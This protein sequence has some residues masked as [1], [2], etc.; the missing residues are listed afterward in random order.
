MAL[1]QSCMPE[2]KLTSPK[3]V[4]A[5]LFHFLCKLNARKRETVPIQSAFNFYHSVAASWLDWIS[6]SVCATHCPPGK[7]FVHR[8]ACSVVRSLDPYVVFMP[9][10]HLK[11]ALVAG[12][13]GVHCRLWDTLRGCAVVT[14]QDVTS[15]GYASDCCIT[16]ENMWG[17]SPLGKF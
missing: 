17:T 12:V 15:D 7:G 1:A 6:Q 13:L 14:Q 11:M 10:S 5:T 3:G 8:K 16:Q 2:N 4:W 9:F